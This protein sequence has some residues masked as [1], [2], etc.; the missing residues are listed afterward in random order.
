MN[1]NSCELLAVCR[2]FIHRPFVL[3]I[4]LKD[5]KIDF[6]CESIL[7]L[8][9]VKSKSSCIVVAYNI[10]FGSST[11]ILGGFFLE[12]SFFVILVY[13]F[14]HIAN[15]VTVRHFISLSQYLTVRFGISDFK[16]NIFFVFV[17]RRRYI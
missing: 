15:V 11:T 7:T 8:P 10:S 1:F 4:V 12:H 5:K 2:T 6:L 13:L 17:G 3:V 16:F 9:S 14:A